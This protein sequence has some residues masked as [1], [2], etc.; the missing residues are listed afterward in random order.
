[1][2]FIESRL[3]STDG[4][5]IAHY[6]WSVNEPK[7]QLLIVHGLSEHGRRYADF[8]EHLNQNQISVYSYDQRGHGK[9]VENEEE[10][11]YTEKGNFFTKVQNDLGQILRSM[12]EQNPDLPCFLMGHSMGSL[13]TR[14]F[15]AAQQPKLDGVILSGT[16]G[17]P[18]VLGK[19]GLLIAKVVGLIKGKE[20]K[21]K[22]LAKL[23][24]GKFNDS[25]VPKRTEFDWLSRDEGQVDKYVNDPLCGSL[26]SAGLWIDL[27]NGVN[28]LNKESTFE[29][30]DKETPMYLFAGAQD[31]VGG[32]GLEVQKIYD[33]YK[34]AGIKNIQ[35]KL[36]PE[37]RHETINETNNQEV[38]TD[39]SNWINSVISSA[40]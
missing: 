29:N 16:A 8:A 13:V 3:T 19:V 20:H 17:D 27:I 33:R 31:P 7:A 34:N 14:S 5:K 6:T 23:S 21:S 32:F 25:I 28:N 35:V 12:K 2:S 40:S 24:F 18:G 39:V 30:T 10:L 9:T 36:Y 22:T 1:M 15:I 37:A 4:K 11:G 26:S 38:Y